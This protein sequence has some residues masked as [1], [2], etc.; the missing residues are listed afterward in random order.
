MSGS[1]SS[2]DGAPSALSPRAAA[3]AATTRSVTS[4][5][6]SQ[7]RSCRPS[8]VPGRG[9]DD[10]TRDARSRA[11][12]ASTSSTDTGTP[13]TIAAVIAPSP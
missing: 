6:V 1:R 8:L 10:A 13:S 7:R 4:T 5:W 11:S 2:S 9:N 3:S 12:R